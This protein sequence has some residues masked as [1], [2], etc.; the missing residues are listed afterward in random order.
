[1]NANN[2][3]KFHDFWA[4]WHPALKNQPQ[5]KWVILFPGGFEGYLCLDDAKE[6][7]A[8]QRHKHGAGSIWK[9]KPADQ[10]V[11]YAVLKR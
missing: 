5:V 7:L 10:M 1:M 3:D 4:F 11:A 9:V 6:D 2:N 8:F